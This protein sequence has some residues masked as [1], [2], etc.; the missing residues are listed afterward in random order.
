M[1][2][3]LRTLAFGITGIVSWAYLLDYIPRE[4]FEGFMVGYIIGG[5]IVWGHYVNNRREE[6][7]GLLTRAG[8]TPPSARAL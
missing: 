6:K 2:A 4:H 5:V 1:V 3:S 8:P 7:S